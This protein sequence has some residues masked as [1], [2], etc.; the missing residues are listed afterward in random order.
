MYYKSSKKEN[1]KKKNKKKKNKKKNKKKRKRR[2]RKRRRRRRRRRRWNHFKHYHHTLDSR[3]YP[4]ICVDV[5][6]AQDFVQHCEV[7][8]SFQTIL[9]SK[10][11]AKLTPNRCHSIADHVIQTI[12]V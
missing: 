8:K 1:K 12:H 7:S 3:F 9:F 4:D 6:G 2:R 10:S 5:T 11:V